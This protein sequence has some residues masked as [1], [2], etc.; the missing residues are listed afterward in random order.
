MFNNLIFTIM[1]GITKTLTMIFALT[2]FN[3]YAQEDYLVRTATNPQSQTGTEEERFVTN[4]FPYYSICDLTDGQKFM[5]IAEDRYGLIPTLKSYADN[6]EVANSKM[7]YKI[8]EFRGTEEK[9]I[10]SYVGNNYDTRF[11]FD[12]EGER[13]YYEVKQQFVSDICNSNPRALIRNL[14]YLGD[15][16]IARELLVGKTLYTK[17]G[18]APNTRVTVTAVGAGT[19][20]CPVKIVFEDEKGN[21]YYRDVLFS[22]TNSGLLD[23]DLVGAHRD[24]YFA[25]AF[26]FTN[27]E[28]KTSDDIRHKYVGRA[29]YPK[30]HIEVTRQGG[31]LETLARYTPLTIKELK[32]APTG[33]MVTLVLVGTDKEVYLADVDLKY[34][35]FIRNENY[36]DDTFGMGDL[37]KQYPDIADETWPLL[38]KGEVRT[39]MSKEECKLALG[40]PIQRVADTRSRYETW[41]YQG[42]TIDFEDG[43]VA[44]MR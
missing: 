20:E 23:S 26:S 4:N 10:E 11:L 19:R 40:S 34:D 16:D 43:R 32:P 22:K 38:S 2:A 31:G 36:I 9:E 14:V 37:R 5:L 3:A 41:F 30:R 12:S 15:V 42:K 1:T 28:Q 18:N 24:K 27:D 39:G 25:N 7:Q 21:S 44:R 35:I 13:Y 8:L 29:V 6:R 33:T 17:V